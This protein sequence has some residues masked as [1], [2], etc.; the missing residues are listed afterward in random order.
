MAGISDKALK[1]QCAQNRYR[2]NGKELQNQEFSDGSGLEEYDFGARMMDPQ[3]GRW[4]SI[5]PHVDKYRA[6]SPYAAFANNPLIFVD[7]DGKDIVISQTSRKDG[8]TVIN[9]TVTGKLINESG[10]SYTRKEMQAY[11]ARIS[12]AIKSF[13][14]S[15]SEK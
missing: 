15:A 10:K 7:P 2:F 9:I 12:G 14:G 4:K 8:T 6:L 1:T 11:A 5:D 13:Y 3:I